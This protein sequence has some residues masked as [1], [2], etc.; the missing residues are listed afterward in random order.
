[1]VLRAGQPVSANTVSALCS[2]DIFV[3]GRRKE[4]ALQIRCCIRTLVSLG[5]SSR[6]SSLILALMMVL[7]FKKPVFSSGLVVV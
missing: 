3:L 5:F 4:V 1:M 6:A 2:S 7:I